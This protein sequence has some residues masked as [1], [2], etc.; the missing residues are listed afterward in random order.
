MQIA[1]SI[2]CLDNEILMLNAHLKN[3]NTTIGDGRLISE[4]GNCI[5]RQA[6]V[7]RFLWVTISSPAPQVPPV[8]RK[9]LDGPVTWPENYDPCQV[10]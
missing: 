2:G 9:I 1:Y 8:V 7:N 10:R 3:N 5:I 4:R 6:A